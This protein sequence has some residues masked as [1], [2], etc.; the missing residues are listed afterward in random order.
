MCIAPS[1]LSNQD[2]FTIINILG[3]MDKTIVGHENV[4]TSRTTA[5]MNTISK[6]AEETVLS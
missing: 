2:L 4:Q 5:T 1:E 3:N 6:E